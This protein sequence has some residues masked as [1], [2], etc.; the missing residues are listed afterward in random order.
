[1]INKPIHP[2]NPVN[3][4]KITSK[5]YYTPIAK[6]NF[7]YNPSISVITVTNRPK[8]ISNVFENYNRQDYQNKELIVILN[9]NSMDLK[10]WEDKANGYEN[11]KIYQLDKSVSLGMCLNFAV[12]KSQYDIIAKFDDD[13]YYNSKYL[14]ETVKF[15]NYTNAGLIGKATSY[16]Y[17][18]KDKILA[19]RFPGK[20]LRYVNHVDGPTMFI[21]REVFDK[22]NFADVSKGED[23]KFSKDC[24]K[25]GIK[26]FST[27][28]YH[29]V[30][31]RHSSP[32]E[33]TW[34]ID[35]KKLLSWCKIVK[36]N[37]SDYSQYI[38]T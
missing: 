5:I 12:E 27:T 19:I 9:C 13:D 30:Y 23:T 14:K 18:E 29:H 32:S 6:N 20:E 21:K 24:I 11:I 15:F 25:K 10:T 17:F 3:K 26:I 33:H 28:K 7:L 2:F 37:I 1:M 34:K 36:K 16:V 22:V 4:S 31:V 8:Y 35:N 38:D